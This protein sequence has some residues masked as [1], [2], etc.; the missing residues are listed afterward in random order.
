MGGEG[1]KRVMIWRRM[2]DCV[3]ASLAL[4]VWRV[5]KELTMFWAVLEMAREMI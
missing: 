5:E 1:E 2:S 4:K 3:N